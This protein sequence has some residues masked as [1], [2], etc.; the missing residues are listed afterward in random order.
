MMDSDS[1][2]H[3]TRAVFDEVMRSDKARRGVIDDYLMLVLDILS[4][5]PDMTLDEA[6]DLAD[7][8]EKRRMKRK[9]KK[10]RRY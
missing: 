2:E 9:P 1:H 3:S 8:Q 6:M 5:V 7:L 10:P 4:L